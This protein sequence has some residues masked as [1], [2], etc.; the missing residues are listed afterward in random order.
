[1]NYYICVILGLIAAII[2]TIVTYVLIMPASKNGKLNK[3][4]QFLHNFFNFKKIYLE[5]VLKFFYV[6]NT[7]GCVT[8][9]FFLLFGQVKIY[10]Y[11][12]STFLTGLLLMILGPIFTRLFYEILMLTIIQVKNIIEINN[13]INSTMHL[14]T[15][16]SFPRDFQS[17]LHHLHVMYS[18]SSIT[19]MQIITIM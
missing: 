12:K 1:M 7:I 3:F 10:R 8:M 16:M 6:L 4:C 15:A 2:L 18:S 19:I 9:G 17:L 13:K 11:S 14:P 5:S